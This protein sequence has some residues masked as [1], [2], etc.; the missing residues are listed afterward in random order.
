MIIDFYKME[1]VRFNMTCLLIILFA[2]KERKEILPFVA[3]FNHYFRAFNFEYF[4]VHVVGTCQCTECIVHNQNRCLKY[5]P[6][7]WTHASQWRQIGPL[8]ETSCLDTMSATATSVQLITLLW[9][10][11]PQHTLFLHTS[12]QK[13][14]GSDW[15]NVEARWSDLHTQ[16]ICPE[17]Y[18]QVNYTLDVHCCVETTCSHAHVEIYSWIKVEVLLQENRHTSRLRWSYIT[19]GPVMK[20]SI[21][22]AQMLI[23]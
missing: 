18:C 9:S 11:T 19:Y 17:S 20:S 1:T 5:P 13:S 14:R 23:L 15:E 2:L 22:P 7:T 10:W 12:P 6:S 3:F 16:S 21:I 4:S 8:M